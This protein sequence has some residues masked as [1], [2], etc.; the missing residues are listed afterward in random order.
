MFGLDLEL[1]NCA[2]GRGGEVEVVEIPCAG[3]HPC[4]N[5]ADSY[6]HNNFSMNTVQETKTWHFNFMLHKIKIFSYGEIYDQ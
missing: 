2:L 1:D 5:Q 3:T 6:Y 4:N